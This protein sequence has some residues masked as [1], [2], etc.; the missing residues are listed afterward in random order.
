MQKITPFLW[1]AKE[2]EAVIQPTALLRLSAFEQRVPVLVDLGLVFAVH[3]ERHCMVERVERAGGHGR[4][5]LPEENE[6]DDLDR[7]RRAAR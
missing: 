3:D 7:P 2:A 5:V 6:L 4:E 1:Y